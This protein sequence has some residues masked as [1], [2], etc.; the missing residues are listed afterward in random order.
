VTK[1][2][3]FRGGFSFGRTGE[4]R[5]GERLA[6]SRESIQLARRDTERQLKRAL[7]AN[8]FQFFLP[9]SIAISSASEQF[10]QGAKIL[11]TK[12]RAG[13]DHDGYVMELEG[14]AQS[15]LSGFYRCVPD[16]IRTWWT[17]PQQ[18]KTRKLVGK[19][20]GLLLEALVLEYEAMW[21]P[22]DGAR[23]PLRREALAAAL[24][25]DT[26][27]A[28][29]PI[30]TSSPI[31]VETAS[32]GSIP[33]AEATALESGGEGTHEERVRNVNRHYGGDGTQPY[34]KFFKPLGIKGPEFT[35]W[36]SANWERCGKRKRNLLDKAADG[37]LAK[38]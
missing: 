19:H 37:L 33:P 21:K 29:P 36:K 18:Q 15:I 23:L 24:P 10:V 8:D 26:A 6:K 30:E 1:R 3:P 34:T 9:V 17:T 31:M 7:Q 25:V 14:L 4:S 32:R 11:L 20:V 35:A 16:E 13:G 12:H 2:S 5:K 28:A 27:L 38:L 22:Q